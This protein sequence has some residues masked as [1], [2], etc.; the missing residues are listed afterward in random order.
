MIVYIAGPMRGYKHF[1]FPAFDQAAAWL[2]I[3]GHVPINPADLD[4]SRG[5]D[6]NELPDDYDWTQIPDGFDL[7]ATIIQDVES[8]VWAD[9]VLLLEGWMSSDGALAERAVARWAGKD[10]YCWDDKDALRRGGK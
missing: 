2:R 10:V 3:Q 9:A 4:R 5:F 7:A 8:V 6:P 1:N